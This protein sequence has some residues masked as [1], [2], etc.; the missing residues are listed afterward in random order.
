MILFSPEE[1]RIPFRNMIYI[2]DSDTDIP[3]MKLVTSYG[4]HSIGVY[5]ATSDNK[6][7]V[8]KMMRDG[9]IRYFAPAD[10]REGAELDSLVKK[11]INRTATYEALEKCYYKCKNEQLSD[12]NKNNEESR[13]KTDLIIAL[14]NSSNFTT[15]H[16]L[17][18]KMLKIT[19]WSN[20]EI[21]LLLRIA[22]RNSQVRYILH[23]TDVSLF[24]NT[25]LNEYKYETEESDKVKHL[26]QIESINS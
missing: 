8:Y 25:I 21:G 13:R 12:D 16:S 24:Y 14:D 26:L 7:K 3:C 9:R 20:D 22:V 15:T 1:I 19:N 4:G 2:G 17:I 5:D 18:A 6:T 11:I 23:D 10:Y